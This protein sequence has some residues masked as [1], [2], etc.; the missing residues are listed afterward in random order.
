M[1]H[2]RQIVPDERIAQI[3]M[4]F[5]VSLFPSFTR[6]EYQLML[7]GKEARAVTD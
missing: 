4:T 7:V 1:P 3:N 5:V 2:G 6:L